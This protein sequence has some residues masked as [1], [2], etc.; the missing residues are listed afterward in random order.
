MGLGEGPGSHTGAAVKGL[1]EGGVVARK[2]RSPRAGAGE[3]ALAPAYLCTKLSW[4]RVRATQALG[5]QHSANHRASPT[6]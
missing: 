2:G 1:W 3:C 5:N 6:G 4:V